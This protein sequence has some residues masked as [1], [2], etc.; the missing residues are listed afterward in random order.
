VTAPTGRV[1]VAVNAD[2]EPSFSFA[3]D[4]AWDYLHYDDA[5]DQLARQTS[6]V[7][8]GTLAQRS[9]T[10]QQA[11]NQFLSA[12]E[13]AV[14][15]FDV[16][17]RQSFFSHD[18]IEHSLHLATVV[19]A[20]EHELQVLASLIGC[21]ARSESSID[22]IAF[23]ICK[24]FDL[25]MLALTRGRFGTV[26]FA[27]NQRVETSVSEATRA[28][29]AD[30]VGAGDACCAGIVFGLLQ[31]WPLVQ[32]LQLANRMG[33]FVASCRGATPMLSEDLRSFPAH[34]Q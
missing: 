9:P 19:K 29:D 30:S 20:N 3:N 11:I 34:G 6:A 15:V 32:T 24:R 1:E 18:I 5:I 22:D 25:D 2:G 10:A 4:V 13:H 14:R 8:F 17:L 16:N 23:E 21:Q 12:A 26:L 7:C 28:P 27:N 33:S 31:R